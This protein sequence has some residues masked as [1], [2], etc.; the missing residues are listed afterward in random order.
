MNIKNITQAFNDVAAGQKLQQE[1]PNRAIYAGQLESHQIELVLMEPEV[2]LKAAG[3]E[4]PEHA[5]VRVTAQNEQ[6]FL[7]P[8]T[9]RQRTADII[10]IVTDDVIIV[11]VIVR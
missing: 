9:T 6:A 10:V 11:I 3:I 7:A 8:R 2:V 4:V 5:T 1:T